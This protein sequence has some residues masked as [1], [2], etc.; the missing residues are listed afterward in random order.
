MAYE[1]LK[2][3]IKQAIK[4]NGNREITGN[5]L[6]STLLSIVNTIGADCKFLGFATPSTVPPTGEGENLFY[7]AITPG[8]YSN[9]KT[10]TG[11]LVIT[12]KNGIFF[13][14]KNATD[15]YWNSNKVFEIVQT[16]GEAEDEVMSQKATSTEL[17]NKFDK[18]NVIQTFG[19]YDSKVMSTNAIANIFYKIKTYYI[20]E[21]IDETDNSAL[22]SALITVP[23]NTRAIPALCM[24]KNKQAVTRLLLYRS[25]MLSTSGP[26]G[27]SV[28]DAIWGNLENWY[29]QANTLDISKL[30][31]EID[32][33][34]NT[35]I[36]KKLDN[37]LDKKLDKSN[38]VQ[39][40]S[41]SPDKV[42][43]AKAISNMFYNL[44]TYN[45]GEIS[46][47]HRP[48]DEVVSEKLL[49]IPLENRA[50]PA[51]IIFRNNTTTFT[52][53]AFYRSY[54]CI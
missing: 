37:K 13:F 27:K 20:G 4:Q 47:A 6:Q 5:L 34:L 33:K 28:T 53:V 29:I 15:S 10:N 21:G 41:N 11:N 44:K 51:A 19:T 25:T 50:V 12:I 26:G 16:T 23:E 1:N 7:F 24:F 3:A 36:D 45:L 40:L 9:F 18:T 52:E 42:M 35:E 31:T 43:S 2:S 32:S 49:G 38:I 48:M 54:D 17:N 30:N 46:T 14:T 22:S 39:T 8:N